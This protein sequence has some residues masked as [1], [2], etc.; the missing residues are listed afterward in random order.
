MQFLYNLPKFNGKK[1]L[2]LSLNMVVFVWWEYSNIYNNG[3][4]NDFFKLLIT[5]SVIAN[6][7]Y[8][9]ERLYFAGSRFDFHCLLCPI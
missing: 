1:L 8:L 5:T 3:L 4:L 7:A 6:S 9:G 2:K